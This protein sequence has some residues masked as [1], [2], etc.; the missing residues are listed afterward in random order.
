[1][2]LIIFCADSEPFYYVSFDVLLDD[3]FPFRQMETFVVTVIC[4]YSRDSNIL[5]CKNIT[6]IIVV[7]TH[8]LQ[9]SPS[10]NNCVL[11]KFGLPLRFLYF[12]S[13][14]TKKL[15]FGSLCNVHLLQLLDSTS[16]LFFM[17]KD[18]KKYIHFAFLTFLISWIPEL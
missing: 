2:Q 5:K 1:M 10:Q 9:N 16:L 14:K 12:G 13:R 17:I 6:A 8:L 7:P 11:N 18:N 4:I 3:G 15:Q